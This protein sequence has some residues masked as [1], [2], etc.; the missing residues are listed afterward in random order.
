MRFTRGSRT[1]KSLRSYS[2]LATSRLTARRRA[3]AALIR[4]LVLS[5]AVYIAVLSFRDT[6]A[7]D[8]AGLLI[9]FL[10]ALHF[11]LFYLHYLLV[12]VVLV[13]PVLGLICPVLVVTILIV[14]VL[15]AVLVIHAF[16]VP[17]SSSP[18]S[19]SVPFLSVQPFS[20]LVPPFSLSV[21][22]SLL[23]PLFLS[24]SRSS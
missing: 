15:V 2:L 8:D 3:E 19:S 9:S 1:A 4:S 16:A 11:I 5:Y 21:S 23:S 12:L 6:S 18:S 22:A 14:P 13:V 7:S 17:S 20:L 24:S 10:N